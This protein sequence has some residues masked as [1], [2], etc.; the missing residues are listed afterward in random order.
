MSGINVGHDGILRAINRL[1]TGAFILDVR[2][3]MAIS[4]VPPDL[5]FEN[6]STNPAEISSV[7]KFHVTSE[8]FCREKE[9][10]TI[11]TTQLIVAAAR[12]H[13]N[14]KNTGS[15]LSPSVQGDTCE[16]ESESKSWF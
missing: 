4:N 12:A 1:A 8:E 6:F 16:G 9:K 3:Y 10:R 11:S 7:D 14:N 5:G 13:R 15:N 2:Q